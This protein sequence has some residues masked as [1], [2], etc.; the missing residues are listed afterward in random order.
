MKENSRLRKLNNPMEFSL[1]SD[2]QRG[3]NLSLQLYRHKKTRTN[4]AVIGELSSAFRPKI[5]QMAT[6]SKELWAGSF[7]YFLFG[8]RTTFRELPASAI[9]LKPSAASFRAN[10]C[11]IIFLTSKCLALRI[12]RDS[13]NS[14]GAAP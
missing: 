2:E 6:N 1:F 12:S 9:S 11:V 7:S 14:F 13:S 10:L 8:S 3:E 5:P 4:N